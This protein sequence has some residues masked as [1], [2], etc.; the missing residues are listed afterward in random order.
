MDE[1]SFEQRLNA[2]VPLDLV[3][4][5][6]E[7]MKVTVGDYLNDKPVI[8]ALVY[9]ECPML[10]TLTLNGLLDSLK[11]LPFEIYKDSSTSSYKLKAFTENPD[12]NDLHHADHHATDTGL[13]RRQA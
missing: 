12:S 5:N 6:S 1:V 2:Q 11:G 8:L 7:G 13:F 4:R 3:F 9:Y 10:C